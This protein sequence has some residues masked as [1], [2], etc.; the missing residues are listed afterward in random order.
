MNILWL[1]IYLIY[2]S[3]LLV[4]PWKPSLYNLFIDSLELSVTTM[5]CIFLFKY[6]D[7]IPMSQKTILN[8]L[9]KILAVCYEFIYI[10]TWLTSFLFNTFPGFGLDILEAYPSLVCF[11]LSANL[12]QWMFLINLVLIILFHTCFKTFPISFLS[13]N[14]L[15]LRLF[16]YSFNM[17]CIITFALEQ[18]T[19]TFCGKILILQITMKLNL[20]IDGGSVVVYKG[21][22]KLSLALCVLAGM[23]VLVSK[24]LICCR[25]NSNRVQPST[26]V[27]L[28]ETPI[29]NDKNEPNAINLP[30]VNETTV[31]IEDTLSVKDLPLKKKARNP[32]CDDAGSYNLDTVGFYMIITILCF[33]LIVRI[34]KVLDLEEKYKQIFTNIFNWSSLAVERVFGASLPLYWLLRKGHSRSYAKRKANSLF[35]QLKEYVHLPGIATLKKNFT[36][37][38]F[39]FQNHDVLN[40]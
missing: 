9:M 1:I 17:A 25:K 30:N 20:K 39:R 15:Y 21:G 24:L 35:L 31:N 3:I 33:I 19:Q 6:H 40:Q 11:T 34:L 23:S 38:I 4:T 8:F 13:W 22:P 29:K 36:A 32:P 2:I 10:F 7:S 26:A 12:P 5:S 14:E 27:N 16:T 18:W 28:D 37:I